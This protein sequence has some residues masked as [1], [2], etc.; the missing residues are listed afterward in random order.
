MALYPKDIGVHIM[1]HYKAYRLCT[2]NPMICHSG[3]ISK[4][5]LS[6]SLWFPQKKRYPMGKLVQCCFLV[7]LE[8]KYPAIAW[9]SGFLLEMARYLYFKEIVKPSELPRSTEANSR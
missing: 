3:A 8:V 2:H 5:I 7:T 9:G 6:I 1:G 4:D